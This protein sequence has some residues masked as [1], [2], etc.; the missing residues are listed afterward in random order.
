MSDRINY[1]PM[2][3]RH[4]G[5]TAV[6]TGAAAGIGR[7][8]A[9]RLAAEGAAVAVLDRAD[10]TPV[11]K[12]IHDAG[13][14]AIA[15]HV[16]LADA[17]SVAA[18]QEEVAERLGAADILVNN[19]GIYPNQPFESITFEQWR[20]VFTLN[21]DALFHTAKAFVP[22]MRERGW[23]RIVNMTSNS[24]GM[25]IPGFSHYVAS[26]MAA[27]GLT[28]GLATDLADAG[29]TVNAIAPSLVRTATTEA[30]PA[31]PFE[32]VPQ[33]QAIRRVQVPEDLT[34]MLSFLV[35]DDAAFITG[36]T[37]FVDGGLIRS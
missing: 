4:E 32:M 12:E 28:R 7:A 35:S 18:A 16:D 6:I 33:L 26:K 23:G 36:Q 1:R 3:G 21:V 20:A 10:A 34:G 5:R 15:V 19:A 8:Y 25:V 14:R 17:A 29:I 9:V 13:G 2:T 37:L 27:I 11:V 30:G 24:V 31:E 22:G